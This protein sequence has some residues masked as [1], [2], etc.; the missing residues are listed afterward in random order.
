MRFAHSI[1]FAVAEALDA[2]L[3]DKLCLYL[4]LHYFCKHVLQFLFFQQRLVC[5]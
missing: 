5:V 2:F 4:I 3:F 1:T